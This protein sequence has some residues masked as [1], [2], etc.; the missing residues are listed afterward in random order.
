MRRKQTKIVATISDLRCDT[1]FIKKLH[2]EGVDVIRLNTAHQEIVDSLRVIKNIRKVSERIAILIDT[3][4]PEIRTSKAAGPIPLEKGDR[5]TI[6]GGRRDDISTRELV[7]VNYANFVK[8]IKVG[9]TI[10]MDDGELEFEVVNKIKNRITCQAKNSGALKSYKTVNVPSIHFDLPSVSEKDREYIDFAIKY[11]IDFIA[12]SF[13][14]NKADVQ[15]IQNILDKHKSRIKIIAKIENREGVDNLDEILDVAHGVMVARGDLGIEIP[16]EELPLTQKEMI[17]KCLLRQ[18]PVIVATQMMQSMTSHPRP[19]RAEV[20][21][22]ANAVFDGADAIM[23][24]AETA[25][26]SYPVETVQIAVK[27]IKE[28]EAC[29]DQYSRLPVPAIDKSITGYLVK[30]AVEAARHLDIKEIIVG[31]ETGFSAEL[32]ASLRA[33]IPVYV[34]SSNKRVVRE[35]A[36]TYGVN[37]HLVKNNTS[38]EDFIKNLLTY[39]ERK[40]KLNSRD[41][42]VYLAGGSSKR[43]AAN[44]ME[45]CEVG[46][47]I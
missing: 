24:S 46:K 6:V 9:T 44:F 4:G 22:V 21:D 19:T 27:I 17:R 10:L 3:K 39:L 14:R 26:G 34:K 47:Y 12:H 5:I 2:D 16:A 38:R 20:S 41:K 25:Q 28:T 15:A 32:L 18:K 33:R 11:D 7:Y 30:A 43:A 40:G 31:D 45:I 23:F 1:D 36:L 42:I 35:L 13:V 8:K 29:A 37:A